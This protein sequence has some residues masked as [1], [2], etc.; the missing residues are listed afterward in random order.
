MMLELFQDGKLVVRIE[1]I[2]NVVSGDFT[3]L[4]QSLAKGCQL[5]AESFDDLFHNC[6]KVEKL[7]TK[8]YDKAE[9]I[10]EQWFGERKYS[11]YE[12]FRVS[13]SQ[14]LKK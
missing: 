1:P 13:K 6:L 8:A 4:P 3:F 12:S 11:D 10:H 7:H 14:R 9:E 2:G 5:N